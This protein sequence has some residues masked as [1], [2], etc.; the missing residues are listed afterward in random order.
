MDKWFEKGKRDYLPIGGIVS[1]PLVG[2]VLPAHPVRR[3]RIVALVGVDGSGK[4]T[5]AHRLAAELTDRGIPAHYWQNAG[6]RRWFGRLARHLGRRDAQGLLGRTGLLWVESLLRWL[7][8]ARALLRSVL[9]GQVAVMD[10]YA[11]CQY[12][13]IRTQVGGGRGEWLARL[14]YAVFPPPDVTFLL[15]V[16]PGEAYQRIELRGTDHETVDYLAAASAAYRSLPEYPTFRAID[17]NGTPDQ[18]TRRIHEQLGL[19]DLEF[20]GSAVDRNSRAA[21][22]P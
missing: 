1:V 14:A 19:A 10:R 5:Q 21:G 20:S 15:D 12:A 6:G 3:P 9:T 2:M 13:S 4:T 22:R 18:V 16:R 11:V 8:I 7:A 17:A